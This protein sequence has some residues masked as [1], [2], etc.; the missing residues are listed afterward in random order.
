M[1]RPSFATLQLRARLP[2]L[3]LALVAAAGA[4][5]PM[6]GAATLTATGSSGLVAAFAFDAGSGSAAAD[7][8]GS[9][10]GGVLSNASWT[11]AGKYG[12]ALSFNGTSSY[13]TVA[14]G[15]SLHLTSGLT[16]EAWV[17]PTA[18]VAGSAAIVAK[19]RTAGGLPYGLETSG[20]VLDGF[21]NSGSTVVASGVSALP[22]NS[23]TYVTASYDGTT[24]RAFV[25]GVQVSSAP[26]SG[27]LVASADPLR[28]GADLTWGEY[29]TG[30]IDNVRVYNRALL[31]SEVQ[32][33]MNTAV[34]PPPPP[35]PPPPPAPPAQ[36]PVAAYAFA[37]GAGSTSADAT[38]NGN[39]A[40]LAPAEE[41]SMLGKFA[42]GMYLDGISNYVSA[43]DTPLLDLSTSFSLEAW[44]YPK[45]SLVGSR[46]V[47]AKERAG[48]GFPYGIELVD[49]V[50]AAY[51]NTGTAKRVSGTAAIPL[52]DWTHLTATY[53]GS[54]IRLYV[55][56]TLAGS[57]AATGTLVASADPLRLGGT[58]VWGEFFLGR[59]D[60]VRIYNRS[61]SAAEVQADMAAPVGGTPPPPAPDTQAPTAPAGLAKSSATQT[62]VSLSW[63]AST[64]NVGVTGYGVYKAAVQ[65]QTSAPTSATV[66]GLACGT[67]YTFAVDA[68]DAALNRSAQSAALNASTSACPGHAGT[69]NAD[70]PRQDRVDHDLGDRVVAKTSATPDERLGALLAVDA[71]TPRRTARR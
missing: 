71:S 39:T 67:S 68:S 70:R 27:S 47:I 1:S 11:T 13:V 56:G 8:S 51:I 53:D 34:A 54:M 29:F 2:F 4:L 46:T 12:G 37:E 64:D 10:N 24:L 48:G 43:N 5:S 57:V 9:G 45:E 26:M 50:P 60:E 3:F 58:A 49:G 63:G 65:S 19:E 62:S 38:G 32:S 25:N 28:I 40:V 16:L 66:S 18:T 69:N 52:L 35:P 61:L 14:D 33:D 42:S 17:Y 59:M 23:W 21:A 41:W 55:N 7:A 15:S 22:L 6:T 36:G 31:A 30:R 44:V 20:G